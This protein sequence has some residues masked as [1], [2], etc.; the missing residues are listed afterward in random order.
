VMCMVF[1]SGGL[2]AVLY[3]K[4]QSEPLSEA[5]SAAHDA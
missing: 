2:G 4:L 5:T 1:G 3:L